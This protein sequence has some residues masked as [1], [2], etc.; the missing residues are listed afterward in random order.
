MK[1]K[2]NSN[3]EYSINFPEEVS[4][5]EFVQLVERLN[6]IIKGFGKVINP[7]NIVTKAMSGEKPEK[8]KKAKVCSE[9]GKNVKWQLRK[10]LCLTCYRHKTGKSSSNK[11]G[12]GT[13]RGHKLDL[14]NS[15]EKIIA[16]IKMKYLGTDEEKLAFAKEMG[17]DWTGISRRAVYYQKRYNITPQEV[18]I[19]GEE[20]PNLKERRWEKKQ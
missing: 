19:E 8:I 13:G 11:G 20:F 5:Y 9:C 6:A 2:I 18:G 14:F 1:I 10:G 17:K 7:T 15:R 3:E 16:I 4:D 12:L